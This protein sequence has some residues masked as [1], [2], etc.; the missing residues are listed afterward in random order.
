[1]LLQ[2]AQRSYRAYEIYKYG[3]SPI[4]PLSANA[5][6]QTVEGGSGPGD[7]ARPRVDRV[8]VQADALQVRAAFDTKNSEL[9]RDMG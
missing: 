3:V 1:M 8:E 7:G 6:F 5:I 2:R 9:R 4:V